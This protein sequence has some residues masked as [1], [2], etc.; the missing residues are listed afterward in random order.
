MARW[1]PC[2]IPASA[3]TSIMPTVN[4]AAVKAERPGRRARLR[5]ASRSR[6]VRRVGFNRCGR[7]ISPWS[8][9]GNASNAAPP[10][11]KGTSAA[12]AKLAVR[13]RQSTWTAMARATMNTNKNPSAPIQR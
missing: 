10:K 8:A 5:A 3:T 7:A 12:S 2:V 9:T 13:A 11:R 6:L 1:M 4:V